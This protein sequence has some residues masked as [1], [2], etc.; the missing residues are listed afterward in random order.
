M[1]IVYGKA[2]EREDI[3]KI[4]EISSQCGILFDT[5]RLLFYKNINSKE[6][7]ERFLN[8]SLKNLHSPFLFNDMQKVVSRI[9]EAK[10]FNQNVLIFGDY[11]ADG[12]CATSLLYQ[13][14]K[15][16]GIIAKFLVPEREEG[17]GLNL[18]KI[19][20]INENEGVDLVITV[21][22]GI[23]ENNNVES[24]KEHGIDVIVSDHH[25]APE[26]L[27][28]CLIVN[29][30]CPNENYPFNGLCGTGVAY[31]IA[32]AL[33]G[34]NANKYLDLV[35]VAT[36]A[37]SMELLD[38]NRDIIKEGLKLFKPNKIRP[39][40]KYLIGEGDKEINVNT[41]AY[42]IAPRVNA[43]GRMG[44][45]TTALKLFTTESEQEIFDI[46]VKLNTYNMQ[47]Q[48]ESQRVY[49]MAKSIIS[50]EKI[51]ANPIICVKGEGWNHGVIG[52]VAAKLVEDYNRPVIV[53]AEHEGNLKG[54][55][56]SIG[57][58]NIFNLI[59]LCQDKLL[60]FGGHSQAAGVSVSK[61]NYD[62]FYRFIISKMK[63][64]Y[65]DIKFEKTIYCDWHI[66]EPIS[67]DFAREITLLEPFG[68]GNKKPLF[69]TSCNQLISRPLKEKSPHYTF[70]TSCITMLDFNG[71]GNVETLGLEVDKTIVFEINYSIFHGRESAKGFVKKVFPD[72]AK[73]S[74]LELEIFANELAKLKAQNSNVT[75]IDFNKNLI[76]KGFG[77]IYTASNFEVLKNYENADKLIPS[78]FNP[79]H[80][81]G[82]NQIVVSL[83]EV[84]E[85]YDRIVYLDNPLEFLPNDNLESLC[86]KDLEIYHTLLTDR[87]EFAKVYSLLSNC[88]GVKFINAVNFYKNNQFSVDAK[89]FIFATEVFF[90]LGF[91]SIHNGL[92]IKNSSQKNEL[93]NSKIYSKILKINSRRVR[94]V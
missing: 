31:K 8:S 67:L 36:V 3:L 25:E 6:K 20:E 89:T 24:L 83:R 70:D 92:L 10:K 57:E 69:T 48:E 87:T 82:E 17:Y 32:N 46:S 38:E 86:V 42:Q 29:P 71:E 15:E 91:F 76:K 30:K 44:D 37:D 61:E 12:I 16:Y 78:L 84:P 2:L 52:I 35:A 65:S 72:Y 28:N 4:N 43:G 7:V 13:A 73:Y 39:C 77:T 55:A 68:M 9:Y 33:L 51:S 58:V 88:I 60:G 47:R 34:E 94:D 64:I 56:R 74:N 79:S 45:A 21:D 1:Q 22:C 54:S 49:E 23:S 5:A 81:T 90:E 18:D 80:Y 19:L 50:Q 40:F 26:I 62:E 27:P 75:Y 59:S 66:D 85:Q 11:D 41:L 93:T 53:F 63:E 14:L